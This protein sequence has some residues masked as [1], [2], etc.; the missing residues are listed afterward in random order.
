MSRTSL[1]L[2]TFA[3]GVSNQVAPFCPRTVVIADVLVAENVLQ[4]EPAM[5]RAFTDAAVSDDFVGVVANA[6]APIQLLQFFFALECA[7]F[8]NRLTPG[9]IGRAGDMPGPLCRFA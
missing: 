7:V 1:R 6:L 9:D 8:S 5:R 2:V 3:D 4:R